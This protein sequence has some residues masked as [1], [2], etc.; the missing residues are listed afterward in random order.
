MIYFFSF[1]VVDVYRGGL[2]SFGGFR[3]LEIYRSNSFYIKVKV[4]KLNEVFE[5]L[6]RLFDVDRCLLISDFFF[7]FS[8]INFIWSLGRSE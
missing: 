8:K 3:S 2:V 6:G 1:S 5:N 4:K 7:L